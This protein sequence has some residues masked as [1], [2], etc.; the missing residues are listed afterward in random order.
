MNQAIHSA[1]FPLGVWNH[2]AATYSKPTARLYLNGRQVGTLSHS[3]C[4][5]PGGVPFAL[6]QAHDTG[7]GAKYLYNGWLD[8]VRLSSVTRPPTMCG[9][10]NT[11]Q[12]ASPRI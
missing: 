8:E 5:Y 7:G 2:V 10:S 11:S 3:S 1:A 9:A 12:P 6:A 4:T